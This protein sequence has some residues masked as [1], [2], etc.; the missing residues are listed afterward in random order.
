MDLSEILAEKVR[1]LLS[2][3]KARDLYDLYML[4]KGGVSVDKRMIQI[5]LDYYGMEYETKDLIANCLRFEKVWTK[6]L[7]PLVADVPDFE[8]VVEF[9][10]EHL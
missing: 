3:K 8:E 6:E 7:Y 1:T 9:I 2:R 10:K 5:K 4:L